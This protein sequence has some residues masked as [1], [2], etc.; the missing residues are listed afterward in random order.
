MTEKIIAPSIAPL[1]NVAL[2]SKALGEAMNRAQ[3]LPGMV[4]FYGPAGWGKSMGAAYSANEHDAH[5]V[6]CSS[7]M[8]KKAFL[9]AI[10][11]DMGVAPASST[12]IYDLCDLVSEH[13]ALSG[14]PLIIDEMDHL[15][16]N[17][18]VEIVRDI[19]EGSYAP[20]LLIGEEHFPNNLKQWERF[21]SRV[22]DFVAA[23]PADASDAA[24]LAKFY[25]P[26][27][28]IAGDLLGEL[29]SDRVSKGS[30][31]RLCVNLAR[32]ERETMSHGLKEVDLAAWTDWGK[33]WFTGDV[34]VRG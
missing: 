33:G 10:A 25:C 3:H 26:K 7:T 29:A 8:T 2:C 20:I 34:K 15:V 1:K 4:V 21:H 13:L 12:T 14:K 28:R 22:L 18:S 16:R 19:Y 6:Q 31:R 24:L 30:V 11:K 17:K 27:I 32:I 5:Y 9:R 23:A